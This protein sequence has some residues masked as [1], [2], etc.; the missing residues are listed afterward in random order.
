MTST[1]SRRKTG[2]VAVKMVVGLVGEMWKLT[3]T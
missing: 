1:R 2:K 3:L